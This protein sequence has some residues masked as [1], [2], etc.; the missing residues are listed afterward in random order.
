[1]SNSGD[2]YEDDADA[3]NDKDDEEKDDPPPII[4]PALSGLPPKGYHT[5]GVP[6]LVLALVGPHVHLLLGGEAL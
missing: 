6:D 5:D 2:D 3:S 4:H 1:M